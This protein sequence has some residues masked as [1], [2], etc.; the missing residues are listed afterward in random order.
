M[1]RRQERRHRARALD[2]CGPVRQP[3]PMWPIRV[4]TLRRRACDSEL[5]L[6]I[7]VSDRNVDDVR[8]AAILQPRTLLDSK[9]GL[10]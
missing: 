10:R 4:R 1:R 3:R 7:V 2:E 6:A 8:T 9:S 5:I